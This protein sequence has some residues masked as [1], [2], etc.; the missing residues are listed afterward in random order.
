MTAWDKMKPVAP[1]K[2]RGPTNMGLGGLVF[3][4]V[5]FGIMAAVAWIL[6]LLLED[7][8]LPYGISMADIF[9]MVMGVVMLLLIYAIVKGGL[10]SKDRFN[11]RYKERDPSVCSRVIRDGYDGAEFIITG[12][13]EDTFG[14]ACE[15]NWQ[16][17]RVSSKSRWYIKDAKG[18]DVTDTSLAT[19]DGIF[20]LIPEYGSEISK[21][22]P[23]ESDEY[24]SI[25]DSVTY[26]D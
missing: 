13:G 12:D 26:Y 21:A 16:F 2:K 6:P 18:N 25:H 5:I 15:A 7:I 23:D 20:I 19:V 24:S 3:L 11:V 4:I 8:V 14:K 9:L 17:Q 10:L 22:E 1:M